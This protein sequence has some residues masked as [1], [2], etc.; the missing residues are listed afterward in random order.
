MVVVV[1]NKCS[2]LFPSLPCLM[3][4][5]KGTVDTNITFANVIEFRRV[6]VLTGLSYFDDGIGNSNNSNKS[7]NSL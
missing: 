5:M 6:L 1:V 3:S 4:C 2:C 7:E